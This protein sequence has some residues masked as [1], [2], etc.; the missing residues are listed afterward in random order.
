MAITIDDVP[1]GLLLL[2][3]EVCHR[4][5]PEGS[6]TEDEYYEDCTICHDCYYKKIAYDLWHQA[7]CLK[8][9]LC[10]IQGEW[11]YRNYSRLQRLVQKAY[12]R[13]CRRWEKMQ[14]VL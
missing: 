10:G 12:A 1:A 11:G 13:E 9:R 6:F 3:C 8:N 2:T 7:A 4:M 5:L 14:C